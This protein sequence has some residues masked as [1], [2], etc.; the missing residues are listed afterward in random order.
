MNTIYVVVF[1]RTRAASIGV[2]IN[3]NR[4]VDCSIF[5]DIYVVF[6]ARK[7]AASIGVRI[8]RN[9]CGDF[10]IFDDIY[11]VF[12]ARS[13]EHTSELQSLSNRVCR[14]LLVNKKRL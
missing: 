9:R 7:R 2:R 5:D 8:N 13:E 3:R 12:F 6:F 4:C 14:I 1:A 10:S 11:I